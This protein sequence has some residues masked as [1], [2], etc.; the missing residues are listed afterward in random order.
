MSKQ[1]RGQSLMEFAIIAVLLLTLLAAAVDL[2]NLLFSYIQLFDA[3]QEGVQFGSFCPNAAK[4][5]NQVRAHS[6]FPIDLNDFDIVINSSTFPPPAVNPIIPAEGN[7]IIVEVRRENFQFF[8]PFMRPFFGDVLAADATARI[9][10][11][12]GCP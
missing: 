3:A 9:I 10:T 5:A 11:T 1:S 7:R 2:G 6:S 12:V 8:L 4:I